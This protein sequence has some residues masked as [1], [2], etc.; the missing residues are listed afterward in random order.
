SGRRYGSR[1]RG[2]ACGERSRAEGRDRRGRQ[3]E[4]EPGAARRRLPR[5]RGRG[6]EREAER[7]AGRGQLAPPPL[8]RPVLAQRIAALQ[9]A[10]TLDPLAPA[11]DEIA[12]ELRDVERRECGRGRWKVQRRRVEAQLERRLSAPGE[13]VHAAG[14][15]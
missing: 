2:S 11:R 6:R 14:A 4:V 7:G 12:A 1:A 9:R 13:Q 3:R 15:E 8:A 5:Q 10:R